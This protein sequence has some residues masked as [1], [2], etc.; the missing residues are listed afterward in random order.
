MG[1]CRYDM[2]DTV[3]WQYTR[4]ERKPRAVQQMVRFTGMSL[5]LQLVGF[6]SGMQ[7]YTAIQHS[8]RQQSAEKT[9]GTKQ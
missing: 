4:P 3:Q 5:Q 2:T 1:L 6:C 9:S 8:N 7:R